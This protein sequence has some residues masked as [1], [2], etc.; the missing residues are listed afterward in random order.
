MKGGNQDKFRSGPNKF[1]KRATKLFI[2]LSVVALPALMVILALAV[3]TR[4]APQVIY[5][6][7]GAGIALIYFVIYGLYAMKVSMG[8]VICLETTNQVV[9]LTTKRKVFTYDVKMGCV[10]VRKKG[11]KYLCTFRTQDSEDTFIFW[12]HAPF[13]KYIDEQFQEEDIRKFCPKYDEMIE[14]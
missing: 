14:E 11:A 5:S 8:T 4:G 10:R 13:S 3:N 1:V 6:V 9:H 12:T 7:S 2:A